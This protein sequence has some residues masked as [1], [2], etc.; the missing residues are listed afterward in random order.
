MAKRIIISNQKIDLS[1]VVKE[2]VSAINLKVNGK[3]ITITEKQLRKLLATSSS[4]NGFHKI[5]DASKQ[6][7]KQGMC[8]I[9]EKYRSKIIQQKSG[10]YFIKNCLSVE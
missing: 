1:E 3:S 9:C 10:K 4:N 2:I 5:V 6:E 7:I 8:L